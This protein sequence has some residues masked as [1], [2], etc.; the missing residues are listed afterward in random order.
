M[1]MHLER[2]LTTTSTKKRKEKITKAKQEELERGW[3]DRNKRLNEMH[4]PKETF[5][6][7]LD[8][9]Y[10]RG[11]KEKTE[12]KCLAKAPT[13]TTKELARQEIVS[14]TDDLRKD[15]TVDSVSPKCWITGPCTTKQTPTYTGTK[16]IGIS[17][18]HKSNGVP[19]FSD[20]EIKDIARMRR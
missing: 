14:S 9:V 2:G 4:L 17:Q 18:M 15:E 1:S 6:Q 13:S 8:W 12:K 10:G 5:E 3:R 11:K 16:M 19:V 20:E 7:Y